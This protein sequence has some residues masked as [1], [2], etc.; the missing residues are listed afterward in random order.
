MSDVTGFVLPESID[1][2]DFIV[3]TYLKRT[4]SS[5]DI[6][7]EAA[8]LAEMQ[9]TGTWVALDRETPA[10][11]DRHGGRIVAL[12][13]VPDRERRGPRRAPFRDWVI[14]IAYP[15]HNIGSQI[16][17]LLATAYGESA[18]GGLLKL[19]D[20]HLPESFV[21][22]FRGPKLGLEGIRARVGATARPLL[23]GIL[24]PAVGL[25]P[26]ESGALF[27]QLALGG[28]DAIKDDELLVSHPW[29]EL[30]ERVRAH[31]RAAAEAF[32]ETGHRTLYFANVTDRPDR[33]LE[34]AHRAV[35]AG[36]TGLMV[37]HLAVG[38]SAVSMLADDPSLDVPILGHLAVAG[39][40]YAGPRSGI[41]SHLVLGKLPRLAGVDLAVYPSPYG[42][43]EFARSKHLRL[44]RA[45]TAPFHGIRSAVPMP[46]GGVHAGVVPLLYADL[47]LDH[48]L[49]AGGA[50]HAHPLGP[51]AGVRAIRQAIDAVVRG[52]RLTTAAR[53]AP[54]LAAALERWP[55]PPGSR[56][57]G[58][59]PPR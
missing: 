17:L 40:M 39:A 56:D 52:E 11:R 27:R 13:E 51:A 53:G 5:S 6:H 14:Q 22:E 28:A 10:I 35:E 26:K 49:G 32:E 7:R 30:V 59:G 34:N 54:E 41:S 4:D 8:T 21:R 48:A 24:K 55:E 29:S 58:D 19:L 33:L 50:V 43:L 25:A 15:A 9:S 3:A 42:G 16:P 45:L 31:A 1:Y 38:I 18:S 57:R 44:A 2:G 36:A 46:G 12:W 47:G 23:V 20:L 37:D